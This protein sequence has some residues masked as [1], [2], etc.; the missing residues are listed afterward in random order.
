MIHPF[1]GWEYR[2]WDLRRFGELGHSVIS[3]FDIDVVFLSEEK[4]QASLQELQEQFRDQ[5]RARFVSFLDLIEA[6][7][8]IQRSTVFVGND[9]GPL[10]LAAA[11]GRPFV[12]LFGPAPPELTGPNI[13]RG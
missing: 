4:D 11:L 2:S 12:G 9:S 10:H 1:A 6:A 8:L 7:V 5:P 13:A 3:E